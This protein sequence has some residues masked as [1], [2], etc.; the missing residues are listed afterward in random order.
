MNKNLSSNN[1]KLF[2]EGFLF[3]SVIGKHH[4]WTSVYNQ[5]TNQAL[6]INMAWDGWGDVGAHIYYY[7]PADNG[8]RIYCR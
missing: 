5:E 7:Y 3:D 1:K 2:V 6:L 8:L 4:L